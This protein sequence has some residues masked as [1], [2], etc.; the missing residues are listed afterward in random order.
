MSYVPSV[1]TQDVIKPLQ[2]VE[3]GTT[4]ATFGVTPSSPTYVAAGIN[5]EVSLDPD[6]QKEDVL[7]LG[8]L[9]IHEQIKTGERFTFNLKSDISDTVL[10]KYGVQTPGGAGTIDA[11]LSFLHSFNIDGTEQFQEM[12]GCRPIN[13]TLSVDRGNW[14]LDQTWLCQEI[15]DPAASGPAGSTFITAPPSAAPITHGDQADPFTWDAVVYD[16]SSISLSVAFDLAQLEVNGQ[17]QIQSSRAATRRI[18]ADVEVYLRDNLLWPDNNALTKIAT[19]LIKIGSGDTATLTD[20]RIVDYDKPLSAT[21]T[22][23]IKERLS[24]ESEA[25]AIA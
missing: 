4:A 19:A 12:L 3:E 7:T 13:T 5:T 18:T 17:L 23:P 9:D 21:S 11:S 6:I 8:K 22:E 14:K 16:T 24:I 1:T 20:S 2:Y 25:V 15:K 10:A